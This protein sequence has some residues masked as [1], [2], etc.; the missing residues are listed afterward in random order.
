MQNYYKIEYKL[1]GNW[2]LMTNTKAVELPYSISNTWVVALMVGEKN[3]TKVKKNTQ[4]TKHSDQPKL[5]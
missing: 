5:S 3:R 4:R 2:Y 1:V